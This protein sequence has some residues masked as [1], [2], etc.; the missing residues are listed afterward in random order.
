MSTGACSTGALGVLEV[1]HAKQSIA[2]TAGGG[3]AAVG[4]SQVNIEKS[5]R[6]R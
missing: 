3:R 4:L 2:K 6:S 5:K 1:S